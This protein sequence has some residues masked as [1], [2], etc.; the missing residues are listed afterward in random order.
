MYGPDYEKDRTTTTADSEESAFESK[1]KQAENRL[2][3]MSL[4]DD[5][6]NDGK[7]HNITF[8]RIIKEPIYVSSGLHS[9]FENHANKCDI[10]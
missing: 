9:N 7:L 4:D 3:D 2:G 10:Q 8:P 5:D 1:M 6:D